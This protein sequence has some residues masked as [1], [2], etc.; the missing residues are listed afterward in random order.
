MS[1]GTLRESVKNAIAYILLKEP[2]LGLMLKRTWIYAKDDVPVASTDGLNIYVNPERFSELE[3]QQQAYVLAHEVLHIV[4]QHPLR[5]KNIIRRLTGKESDEAVARLVNY[6]ADAVVN[7]RLGQSSLNTIVDAV[8]CADLE[9]FDIP[10]DVCERETLEN[11]IEM[12]LRD[13]RIREGHIPSYVNGE[14]AE[15]DVMGG[16]SSCGKIEALNEGDGDDK[17]IERQPDADE[18][19]GEK[20]VRK[21]LDSYMVSKS[22]GRTPAYADRLLSEI[23][24]PKTDWRQLLKKHLAGSNVKRTWSRPSRKHP[25]FPGKEFVRKARTVVMVDTSGSISVKELAQFIGEVYGILREKSEV[26]VIP[27][28]ATVYEPTKLDRP[29]DINKVK[30]RGGGGTLILP[31]LELVDKSYSNADNI[32]ILSDWHIGDLDDERVERLLRKYRNRIVAVTTSRQPPSYLRSIKID[33][34]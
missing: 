20:I 13:R 22:I 33:V 24:K 7:T 4:L 8:R 1:T 15:S 21:F 34:W 11:L 6:V 16:R 17:D 28:D 27:W 26:V 14:P 32:V 29:S 30:I 19:I 18:R 2:L 9:I 10:K 31:A 3:P 23:L 5:A 25:D 12:M